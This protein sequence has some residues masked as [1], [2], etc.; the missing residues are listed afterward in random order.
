M[1]MNSTVR[2]IGIKESAGEMEGKKFSSTKFHLIVDVAENSAGRSIGNESRPFTCGD[3]T[4]FSKWENQ[5]AAWPET[6]IYVDCVFDVVAAADGKTKL[7]LL[8]IKPSPRA[9]AA[10]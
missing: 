9:K 5:K 4:E 3:A 6:G 2:C 7:T 10:A 8:E 1:K